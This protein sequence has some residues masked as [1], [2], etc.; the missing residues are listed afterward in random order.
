MYFLG[1]EMLWLL[2]I[3][4]LSILIYIYIQRRRK[5]LALR[6]ASLRLIKAAGD[7]QPGFRRHIPPVLFIISLAAMSLV[8]ASPVMDMTL[9]FQK[10]TVILTIDTS[11]SMRFE[12]MKPSR[13]EAARSAAHKFVQSQPDNTRL[14]VVSFSASAAV[15]QSPTRDREAEHESINRLVS[16]DATAIGSA[17]L[18][19]LD[20]IFEEPAAAAAPVPAGV[21]GI[22]G[23]P[24]SYPTVASGSFIPAVIVL[25]SDGVNNTGPDPLDAAQK[26]ADS[27][28]RIYTVGLVNPESTAVTARNS[29]VRVELD[30]KT[31]KL[32]AEKTGG[33]YLNAHNET[34]LLKVYEN[35]GTKLV[36]EPERTDL[37][38]ALIG[39]AAVMVVSS[40][41]L[42]L[43]WFNRSL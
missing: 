25:L 36:F 21:K 12:D 43:F 31:L 17:I 30:E 2:W 29:K 35:L 3:I 37:S 28:V 1:P 24:A 5:N 26:A 6:Y 27:G 40:G 8:L 11:S 20:A 4:P 15:V 7:F 14:G 13:L 42:S 34:D 33:L 22:S 19:S 18:T 38:P 23:T 39:F 10:N 41:V 9:P 32:I 16:Q